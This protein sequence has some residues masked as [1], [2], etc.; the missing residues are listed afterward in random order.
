MPTSFM[1]I[2]SSLLLYSFIALNIFCYFLFKKNGWVFLTKIYKISAI[3]TTIFIVLFILTP[4]DSFGCIFNAFILIPAFA[5]SIIVGI[6]GLI[7]SIY[8]VKKPLPIF[9]ISATLI[10]PLLLVFGPYLLR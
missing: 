4:C 8:Y 9:L 6:I 7:N 10:I 3:V 5:V 2:V 1:Q